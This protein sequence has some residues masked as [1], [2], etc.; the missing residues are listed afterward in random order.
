MVFGIDGSASSFGVKNNEVEISG[1]NPFSWWATS[2][3]IALLMMRKAN[4]WITDASFLPAD[5]DYK[6]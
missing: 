1:C 4:D 2:Y 5:T 3:L 6:H